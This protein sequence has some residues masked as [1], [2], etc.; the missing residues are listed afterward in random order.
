MI[1]LPA[2]Q[3]MRVACT[4]NGA[5]KSGHAEGRT[6]LSDFLRHELHLYGT[7]VGCEHG[8]CGAC[9][10]ILDG[11]LARSCSTLA[12]QADGAE[13]TTIEGLAKDQGLDGLREAFSR[14]GALQC[15]SARPVFSHLRRITLSPIP[16]PT[17]KISV[18][19]FRAIYAAAPGMKAWSGPSSSLQR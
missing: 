1:R 2:G 3:R 14:H 15:G 17:K 8:V 10:V 13:I 7:H 5:A 18:R 12:V 4:V 19:C 9:T 16:I 11:R 6:L